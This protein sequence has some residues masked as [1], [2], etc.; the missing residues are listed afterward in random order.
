MATARY[1]LVVIA[2]DCIIISV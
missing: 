1:I 2:K